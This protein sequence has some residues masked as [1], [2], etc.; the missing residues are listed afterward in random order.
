VRQQT[1]LADKAFLALL[2]SAPN[3]L[4]FKTSFCVLKNSIKKAHQNLTQGH[5]S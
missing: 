5:A 4:P 2:Q 1:K 3:S